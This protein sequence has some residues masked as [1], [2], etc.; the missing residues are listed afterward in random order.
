MSTILNLMRR[1]GIKGPTSP[2]GWDEYERAKAERRASNV[3]NAERLLNHNGVK[4]VRYET[5]NPDGVSLV[6][7][8]PIYI[9]FWPEVGK[10]FVD[11]NPAARFGVRNL[12][13]FLKGE[14]TC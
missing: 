8:S 1:Q 10:W 12:I 13:K 4:F 3:R 9:A 5:N 11:G 14:L 7:S 6:I 2:E